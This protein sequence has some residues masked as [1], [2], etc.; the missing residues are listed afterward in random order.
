MR[1]KGICKSCK[2]SSLHYGGSKYPATGVWCSA[3]N[4]R[5]KKTKAPKECDFYEEVTE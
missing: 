5:L 4:G 2:H 1:I 3:R